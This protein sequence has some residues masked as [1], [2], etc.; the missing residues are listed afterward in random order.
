MYTYDEYGLL[1][2]KTFNS[3]E[4]SKPNTEKTEDALKLYRCL[5]IL[6]T[7]YNKSVGS[8]VIPAFKTLIEICVVI[9]AYGTIRL[10]DRIPFSAY[11]LL[12]SL[13]SFLFIE[14]SFAVTRMA[15]LHELS[16]QFRQNYHLKLGSSDS[17]KTKKYLTQGLL[18]CRPLRCQLTRA[19][20]VEKST[21]LVL[22]SMLFNMLV[23]LL[24]TLQ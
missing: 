23:S 24:M 16:R 6:N 1:K 2:Y 10:Y 17:P 22:L 12:P 11:I 19:L 7:L 21:K 13:A 9:C 8:L 5:T 4:W 3:I 20:F 14:H 15:N 18:S